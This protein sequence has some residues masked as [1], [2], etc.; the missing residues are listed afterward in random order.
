MSKEQWIAGMERLEEDFC[1]GKISLETFTAE[2]KREYFKQSEI[3]E[4]V[5]RIK[6]ERGDD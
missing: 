5:E 1:D 3:D 2:M 6:Q 4:I